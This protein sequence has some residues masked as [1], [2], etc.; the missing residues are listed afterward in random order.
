MVYVLV[1]LVMVVWG[2][3]FY[4]VFAGLKDD[5]L[6]EPMFL[7]NTMEGDNA[8]KPDT[9]ALIAEY[10]D[11]FLSGSVP[12][13]KR[14]ENTS[15]VGNRKSLSQTDNQLI[16][17]D[18]Q[19]YGIISNAKNWNLVGLIKFQGKEYIVKEGEVIISQFKIVRL[20]KESVVLMYKDHKYS[21]NRI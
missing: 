18:V 19:Y 4:R 12:L 21:I 15:S 5:S 16:A 9:F 7:Y 13:T 11:P 17:P 20:L 1:P 2:I 6:N 3:I 14:V 8:H 10:R